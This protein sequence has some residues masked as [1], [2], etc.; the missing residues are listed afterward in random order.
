MVYVKTGVADFVSWA[1]RL[2]LSEKPVDAAL[3]GAVPSL[4]AAFN[5]EVTCAQ[6]WNR[7]DSIVAVRSVVEIGGSMMPTTRR[8]AVA[9]RPVS[10]K[11]H[12]A[13]PVIRIRAAI[14]LATEVVYV[15]HRR[16]PSVRA[17]KTNV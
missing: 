7:L 5:F 9:T 13:S 1:P 6:L 14:A 3:P 17:R 12:R 2:T 8:P 15:V 4:P 16:S 10:Q 11:S